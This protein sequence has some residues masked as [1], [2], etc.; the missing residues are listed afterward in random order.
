M[1]T[2]D[3]RAEIERLLGAGQWNEARRM[4]ADLW[5]RE[6]GPAT[7]SFII[8]KFAALREHVKATP[9]RVAVLRSF[10]VEPIVP[11]LQ[12]QGLVNGLDLTV[13]TG[14]FNAYAQEILDAGSALYSFAPNVVIVA[15]QTRDL[16]PELWAD[17]TDLSEAQA[18]DAVRHAAETLE[19]LVRKFRERSRASLVVHNFEL[20]PLASRGVLDGQQA[21]GQAAAI[22]KL[23]ARL[24]EF[25]RGLAG[26]YVLDMAG[27]VAQHGRAHWYDERKW[28]TV[29][30]PIAAPYL[31]AV[32]AEWMRFLQPLSGRVAKVVA[33][34]LD[35]TLWG[36][37]IGEDGMA[38]IRL[39][40]EHPGAAYRA[41][42]RALLDLYRR[43]ILLAICSKNNYDDAMEVLEKH[44][45]ML[46]RPEHFAAMRINW[47]DKAQNLREIAA[48]LSLGLDAFAFLDDNPV[49]RQRMASEL[50][51]VAVLEM[52]EDPALFAR[53]VRA[54]PIFER[55]ALTEEDRQ[56]GEMY[57]SQRQ[58]VELEQ[59]SGSREEFLRSLQ[60]RVEIAAVSPMTLARVAQLTQKTNQF[61]VTTRRYTEQQIQEMSS[62]PNCSVLAMRVT[63][64][65]GDNGLVGVAIARGAGDVCE[66][67]TF[68]LSCRVI[69]RGVETA[70][71]SYVAE[72]ARAR[73]ATKLRG[74]FLPTK[75][76][77]PAKEF[78]RE[79]GFRVV[80][81][82]NGGTLWEFDLA[83]NRI[84]WPEWTVLAGEEVGRDAGR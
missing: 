45:G 66:M 11:L 76:N 33:V 70:F 23:N 65:Y 40:I 21:G 34:D 17:F 81:E 16:A 38:G 64:R 26:V 4:L 55:L 25:A 67:D 7:A 20:P 49:E 28:L 44:P 36:G 37:V 46:L 53:M 82:E 27:L 22:E 24:A 73:G 62:D 6:S 54:Q 35:N 48:E 63:D 8:A 71:L 12:A 10:T 69:G 39:G 84:P 19:G 5:R 56:R 51:E 68:L 32:A 61:N 83:A 15:V 9:L 41:L 59:K 47:E 13:H 2:V 75:K 43:G 42:Q 52:P 14:E 78:Y 31:S 72:Q 50:P 3:L 57:A 80:R 29:R 1:T 79:H 30:L 74:W 18:E 58:R 60:Q 77:T